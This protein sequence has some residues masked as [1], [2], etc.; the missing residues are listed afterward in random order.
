M[1]LDWFSRFAPSAALVVL[2]SLGHASTASADDV[3]VVVEV[4]K[5][6]TIFARPDGTGTGNASGKGPALFAG[7]DGQSN[8]KRSLIAF[9]L[10]AAAIPAGATVTNVTMTLFVAQ[11]AGSGGGGGGSGSRTLRLFTLQSDWGEGP[12]GSPT[13]TTVGGTGQGF[14][15]QPGDST[16][17]YA[18]LNVTPWLAPGGDVAAVDAASGTFDAPFAVNSPLSWSS[19]GMLADVRGWMSGQALNYGWLIK[20]DLES[21]PTS[22]VAFW[23]RDGAL[24][25]NNPAIAPQL[26][27][28]YTVPGAPRVP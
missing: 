9:D 24:A 17:D 10:A 23:S 12:S 6:A 16:W 13:S 25:N 11:V 5:D 20:S 8:L 19:P 21:T 27:I 15:G 3:T 18:M 7:T 26:S 1:R 4:A 28:T 14:V 2:G 22:F